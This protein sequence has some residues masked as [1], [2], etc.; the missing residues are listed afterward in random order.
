M[1]ASV[2]RVISVLFVRFLACAK[3]ESCWEM[4][5]LLSDKML[6]ACRAISLLRLLVVLLAKEV[7]F[8]LILLLTGWVV[9]LLTVI[10]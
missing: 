6:S 3:L 7:V 2:L 10:S 5:L 8:V 1:S 9:L 4:L